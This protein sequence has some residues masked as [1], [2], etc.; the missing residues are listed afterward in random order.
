MIL[1]HLDNPQSTSTQTTPL[2]RTSLGLRKNPTK[3]TYAK[4]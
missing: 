2:K 3:V 1:L 4:T